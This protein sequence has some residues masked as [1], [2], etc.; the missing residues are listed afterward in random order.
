MSEY[1]DFPDL[2]PGALD[3]TRPETE[4][5][6]DYK[7]EEVASFGAVTWAEKRFE[8]IE[9]FPVRNQNGSGSCVSQS[10]ALIMGIENY[11]EE[12]KFVE[13]SAKDIYVR[14]SNASPGMIGVEALN[15]AKNFGA[16]LETLM[17]SQNQGE[18]EINIVDRKVSDE[19]IAKIFKIKGFLQLP[20]SIENIAS[21][22][23]SGRKNGVGKPVMT[24][25]KFPRTEWTALPSLTDSTAD[26][27]HHSVTA[28]DYG[29]LNGIKGLFTQDSWGLH[30]STQKGLRFIAEPYL[31]RMTFCAYVEDLNNNWRDGV[32]IPTSTEKLT[33]DLRFGMRDPEVMILQDILKAKQLFPQTATSTGY[34]GIITLKAVK[35]FQ[36]AN[37]LISDGMVG[38]KTREKLNS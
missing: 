20:F 25:Y 12:N 22:I 21:I 14:R 9:T 19:Q 32:P 2:F 26:I 31:K 33:K 11:L 17:P 5:E 35:A 18:T 27:V 37:G 38:Q 24:W 28:V 29:L 7:A 1:N 4:K 15:I 23:E 13:L 30:S 6:K 16:T 36:S 34:F 10:L 3:D 8:N